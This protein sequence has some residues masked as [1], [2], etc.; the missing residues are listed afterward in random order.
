[1]FK[2]LPTALVCVTLTALVP[3]RA[4]ADAH[5]EARAYF[6]EANRAV[7]EAAALKGARRRE[8]LEAARGLYLRSLE[9][10]RNRNVVYNLAVTCAELEA[11]DDAFAFF[12]EYL[13]VEDL[14]AEERR[15]AEARLRDVATKVITVEVVTTPP[16]AAVRVGRKDV[17]PRGTAPLT[18]AVTPGE[19]RL[20]ASL[21]AHEDAWATVGGQ[22]G[23]SRQ[24]TLTLAH[25]DV[26]VRFRAPEGARLFVDDVAVRESS[27]GGVREALLAPG[28]HT[29]RLGEAGK[30]FSF[31]VPSGGTTFDVTLEAPP[32][33]GRLHFE[34]NTEALVTVDGAPMGRGKALTLRLPAGV[35]RIDVGATGHVPVRREVTVTADAD[36]N[37]RVS[38]A[39]EG[40]ADLAPWP[41]VAWI[42]TGAA[43]V[44]AIVLS[45][46][47]AAENGDYEA[48]PTLAGADAVDAANLRADVFW[49]VTA[50]AGVTALVLTLLDGG[51]DERSEMRVTAGVRLGGAPVPGGAMLRAEVR[52]P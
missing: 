28:P 19:H 40:G 33:E 21:D 32:A 45:A 14:S 23:E 44:T 51:G 3:A 5:A 20:L 31:V 46:V 36:T 16:G 41:L 18:L 8:L 9:A 48:S 25:V 27:D 49:G 30:P 4:V 34:A 1:M 17:A 26:R 39:R 29:A 47:A 38:L 11:Y 15:D 52:L 6:E 42:G 13:A 2:L 12:R 50:A 7:A 24:V 10:A 35:H 37:V 22:A 43:A